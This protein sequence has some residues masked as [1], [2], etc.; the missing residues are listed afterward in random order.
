MAQYT[1]KYSLRYPEP[2]DNA[3]IPNDIEQLATD[4]DNALDEMYVESSEQKTH[5]IWID[6]K[7]IYRNVIDCGNLPDATTKTIDI[8]DL[9]IDTP[10]SIIGMIRNPEGAD[11]VQIT[12]PLHDGYTS[13]VLSKID[14]SLQNK[15]H[16]T[17]SL[18]RAVIEYTKNEEDE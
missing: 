18:C 13:V 17:A 5:K 8:S 1:E 15:G 7:R 6:G 4:V 11:D 10:I 14:I 3:N 2:S 9:N 16:T 12:L